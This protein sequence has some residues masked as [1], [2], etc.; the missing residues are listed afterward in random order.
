VWFI[1]PFDLSS[2]LGHPGELEHPDVAAAMDGALG[3]LRARG[4]TVGVFARDGADALE[5]R[6]RGAQL[7]LLG[8]DAT[9]LA[10]AAGGVVRS[11][12]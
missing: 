12:A 5:W 8:S 3:E 4:A 1:G 7:I 10:G 9:L 11:L 6:T 2:D